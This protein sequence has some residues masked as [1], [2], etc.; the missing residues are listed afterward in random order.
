MK[1]T[2]EMCVLLAAGHTQCADRQMLRQMFYW[3]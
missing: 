1:L 2:K 3:R